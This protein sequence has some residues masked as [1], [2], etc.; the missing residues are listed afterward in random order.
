MVHEHP[1]RHPLFLSYMQKASNTDHSNIVDAQI[2][3]LLHLCSLPSEVS[4][5]P[6]CQAV[7]NQVVVGTYIIASSLHATADHDFAAWHS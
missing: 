1:H 4:G 3:V 7:H 5:Q 2:A 6:C